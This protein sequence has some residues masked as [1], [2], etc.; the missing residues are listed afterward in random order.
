MN[1]HYILFDTP[2]RDL[3]YPF[4]HTRPV[5]AFK[6]GLLTIR[7]KWERWL[8]TSPISYFTTDYLQ[9]KYPLQ[10]APKGAV[11][12][13]L[14]GHLLPSAPLLEVIRK[15]EPGQELYKDGR[16]LVKVISGEDFF[17]PS[18]SERVNYEGDILRIDQ[19][20]HIFQYN[21]AAIR[22]DFALLT[23]GRVSAPLS[24]TNQVL[25][26]E[27]IFIEPGAVVEC[28]I[29]NATAGPIYIG[30]NAQVMEG[31]MIRGPFGLGE[32]SVLKM[33]SRIYGATA[34]G[35][36][37]VAGGE[38]KN[39]VIFDHSNKGHDGY[40]G[41]AVIGEWCNLGAHTCCSNMKNNARE[42]RI[43]ME[44]RQE[45]WSA[46]P[47]CGVLMGDFSRCSINTMFNTGTVIGVSCNVFGPVFPPKFLP[48]FS[49]G[50]TDRYRLDEALRD[51]D[52][53]MQLKGQSLTDGDTQILTYVFPG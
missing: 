10:K 41:D 3:L 32:S 36:R 31:S 44:A 8:N 45:A 22:D 1:P 4:A 6:V 12:I 53:W 52:A 11:T 37:C 18:T 49:W 50:G 39:S 43:W 35:S 38:I 2:E 25:N 9:T 24:S 30:K 27:N 16:L 21:D 13:L 33:G 17:S 42:V 7:E 26:H 40:L 48:S 5:A 34:I 29:L 14:N 23:A 15:L 51:A 28:S 47:K 20:W 46:G 19:P